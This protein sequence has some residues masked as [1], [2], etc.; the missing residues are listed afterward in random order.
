MHMHVA[1]DVDSKTMDLIISNRRMLYIYL[2][3][4]LYTLPVN[5]VLR[6][7]TSLLVKNQM[8]NTHQETYGLGRE[9]SRIS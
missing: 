1:G 8:I 4:S 6:K 9:P 3:I 2:V 7:M 5:S